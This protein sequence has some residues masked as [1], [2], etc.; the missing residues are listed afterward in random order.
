MTL[1]Y[2]LLARGLTGFLRYLDL[3]YENK[4]IDNSQIKRIFLQ[5]RDN[6]LQDIKLDFKIN[7]NT[8][9]STSKLINQ[10][11][12]ACTEDYEISEPGGIRTHDQELKRLLLCR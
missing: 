8:L 11:R 7:S 3:A 4:S 12:P 5:F 2:N 6:Y 1:S 9:A 10:S